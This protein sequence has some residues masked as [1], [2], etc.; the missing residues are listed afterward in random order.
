MCVGESARDR[1]VLGGRSSGRCPGGGGPGA[2]PRA[3]TASARAPG[4]E[5]Q[6]VLVRASA[7]QARR[8][9]DRQERRYRL[10]AGRTTLL[11]NVK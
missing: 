6:Q 8:N 2:P 5:Q 4:R 7:S 1:T 11:R 9:L 10:G 3:A